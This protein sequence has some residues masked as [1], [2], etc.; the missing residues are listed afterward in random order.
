MKVAEMTD[1]SE[2]GIGPLEKGQL[3]YRKQDYNGALAAFTEV[4]CFYTSGVCLFFSILI[5]IFVCCLDLMS[6]QAQ[7]NQVLSSGMVRTLRWAGAGVN[8]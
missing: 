6:E 3:R 2:E 7:E 1:R 5:H 8:L 4:G